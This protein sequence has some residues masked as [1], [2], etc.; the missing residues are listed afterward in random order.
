MLL[1]NLKLSVLCKK[2]EMSQVSRGIIPKWL[3]QTKSLLE[4]RGEKL[5]KKISLG[6]VL[7]AEKDLGRK[8]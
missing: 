8:S 6:L 2:K 5:Q 3:I 7:K 1:I 4:F